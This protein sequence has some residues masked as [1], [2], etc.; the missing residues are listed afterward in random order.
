VPP[1]AADPAAA[2]VELPDWSKA[3]AE[4]PRVPLGAVYERCRAAMA[5]A[6]LR[7]DFEARRLATK[8]RAE[9]AL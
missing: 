5:I 7:P 1:S 3:P 9:F 8:I 2:V 4:P 6:K